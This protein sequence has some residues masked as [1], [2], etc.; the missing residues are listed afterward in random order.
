MPWRLV[1]SSIVMIVAAQSPAADTMTMSGSLSRAAHTEQVGHVDGHVDSKRAGP[2][3][4]KTSAGADSLRGFSGNRDT[5]RGSI[6]TST[7]E[8]HTPDSLDSW[9]MLLVAGGLVVLQLRR[10]QKTLPQRPLIES[11]SR[12]YWG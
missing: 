7:H 4:V 2:S 5:G 8:V 11:E 12:L 9:L 1:I 3:Q 10:K 6:V